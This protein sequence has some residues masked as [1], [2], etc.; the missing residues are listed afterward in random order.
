MWRALVLNRY[1][2]VLVA[3]ALVTIT[4]NLYVATHRD[5]R[6]A[7]VVVGPDG[8]PVA[9]AIVTLRERTLTTLEPRATTETDA[10]GAFVFTDQRLHHFVLEARKD[11]VGASPRAIF[12]LYFRGQGFMLPAPLRLA[13]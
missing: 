1:V 10:G 9:G 8:R 12:R 2:V 3:I 4:W 5:G 7:G 11:G 13:G 6:I